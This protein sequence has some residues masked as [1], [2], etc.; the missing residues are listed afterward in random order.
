MK[1]NPIPSKTQKVIKV[2]SIKTPLLGSPSESSLKKIH[3]KLV[4]GLQG[5]VKKNGFNKVVLGLS[6]GIDSALTLKI[7]IDALGAGNV[8]ALIL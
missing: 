3:Q 7:T 8:A 4:T 5:Y 2:N 6:G 1:K